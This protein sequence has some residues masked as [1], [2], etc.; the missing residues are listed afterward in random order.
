MLDEHRDWLTS[1]AEALGSELRQPWHL[2]VPDETN[3]R[4]RLVRLDNDLTLIVQIPAPGDSHRARFIGETP[5]DLQS[6]RVGTHADSI[7]V[8]LSRGPA[9][10][11]RDIERRLIPKE[12]ERL[13][14]LRI[15][16][17]REVARTAWRCAAMGEMAEALGRPVPSDWPPDSSRPATFSGL[18]PSGARVD[19]VLQSDR[20]VALSINY[21]GLD[22]AVAMLRRLRGDA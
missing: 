6:Y 20:R 8:A 13:A 9:S 15:L 4:S 10:V 11:A 19:I 5:P 12:L 14:D 1:V 18:P 2:Q 17:D 3:R 22:T 7:T 21:I 16:R